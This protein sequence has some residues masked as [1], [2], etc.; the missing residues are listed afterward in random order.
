M[1]FNPDKLGESFARGNE[2][3]IYPHPHDPEKLV[4]E[5]WDQ[6]EALPSEIK[7]R[8]YL[9]KILHLLF[10]KNIPDVSFAGGGDGNTPYL[11]MEKKNLD[12]RHKELRDRISSLQIKMAGGEN[13]AVL[14][15]EINAEETAMQ[16]ELDADPEFREFRKRMGD[17]GLFI[18][19][20]A[21]NFGR[22]EN[23]DLVYVDN[24]FSPWVAA[25]DGGLLPEYDDGLYDAIQALGDRERDQAMVYYNRLDALRDGAEAQTGH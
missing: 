8:Y 9:T 19:D 20:A 15:G 10:P 7:G 1:S 25:Q 3:I 2:K 23:G 22:D 24:D 12:A 4:A 14:S 5:L 11:V 18:D 13:D 21:R 17:M 6:K 16:V